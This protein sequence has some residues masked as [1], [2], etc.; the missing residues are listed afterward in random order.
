MAGRFRRDL[1]IALLASLFLAEI[2]IAQDW[3][4]WEGAQQAPRLRAQLRDKDQNARNRVAAVEVQVRN[5]WLHYPNP[6]P[7]QG[8]RA[9][10]LEYKLDN[11][12]PILTTDTRLRFEGLSSGEHAI[13]VTLVGEDNR[14]ISPPARLQVA[15]P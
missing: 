2:A 9:A 10:V 6:V 13:T 7:Q 4:V 15:I 1:L 3:T 5:V 11:C 12:A 14:T 8:I